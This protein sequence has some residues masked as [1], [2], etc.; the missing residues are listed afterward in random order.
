[1]KCLPLGWGDEKPTPVRADVVV[2]EQMLNPIPHRIIKLH[3]LK[4][5]VEAEARSFS[6]MSHLSAM[7]FAQLSHAL[8][9][10]DFCN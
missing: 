8:V 2:L 7:L 1:M 9:L 6:A 3:A 5:D 4:T 10:N